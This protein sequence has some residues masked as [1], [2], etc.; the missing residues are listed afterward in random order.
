MAH[1]FHDLISFF[2]LHTPACDTDAHEK[3]GQETAVL[4]G[5]AFVLV[6]LIDWLEVLGFLLLIP[7]I[8]QDFPTSMKEFQGFIKAI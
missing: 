6:V 2:A 4:R 1:S 5:L 3:H 7:F 8:S